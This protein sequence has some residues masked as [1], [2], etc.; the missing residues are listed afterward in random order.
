[1]VASKGRKSV[2]RSGCLKVALVGLMTAGLICGV[3]QAAPQPGYSPSQAFNGNNGYQTGS[4]PYVVGGGVAKRP[5]RCT[6]YVNGR[7][8][9]YR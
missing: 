9:R 3:A 2:V 5:S 8:T 1:M 6:R 7:C 4:N